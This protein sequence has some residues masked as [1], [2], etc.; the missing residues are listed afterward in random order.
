M[1]DSLLIVVH[2]FTSRVLM[3]FSADET[4][5]TVSPKE[6][7]VAIM[8]LYKVKVRLLNRNTDYF[9]IEAGTLTAYLFI[10]CLDYVLRT[11]IDIITYTKLQCLKSFNCVQQ[12]DLY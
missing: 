8:T 7:V 5:L 4:L 10:I 6:T 9:D 11:F 1:T 3:S 2:A 12:N